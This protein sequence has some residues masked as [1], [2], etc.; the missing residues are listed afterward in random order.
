MSRSG[1]NIVLIAVIRSAIIAALFMVELALETR[2][3]L[4]STFYQKH[5]NF[6]Q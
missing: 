3:V 4:V 1:E 5:I 6:W 2:S